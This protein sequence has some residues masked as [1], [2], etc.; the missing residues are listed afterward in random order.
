MPRIY[1]KPPE[2]PFIDALS[3]ISWKEK[4]VLFSM[5]RYKNQTVKTYKMD[6]SDEEWV[7]LE[8]A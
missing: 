2:F 1:N 5:I 4:G 3:S 6:D 7:Q 8:A